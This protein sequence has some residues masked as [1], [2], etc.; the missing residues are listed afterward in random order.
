MWGEAHEIDV[1]VYCKA[2][3]LP[4]LLQVSPLFCSCYMYD[5]LLCRSCVSLDET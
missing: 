1:C 2:G 4:L 5:R 3:F